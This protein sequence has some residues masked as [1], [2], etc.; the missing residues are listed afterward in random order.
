[1]KQAQDLETLINDVKELLAQLSEEEQPAIKELRAR[2]ED[3]IDSTKHARESTTRR[4]GRYATSVDN[5][6]TGYPRLGFV[7]GL[8]LGG[9][10]VYAAGLFGSEE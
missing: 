6:I 2:I 3:A 7:T 1:M 10:I 5:Y 8:V 9:V 4:I